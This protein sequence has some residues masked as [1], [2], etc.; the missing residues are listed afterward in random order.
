MIGSELQ[1]AI[2]A[3]LTAYPAIAGGR[4]YDQVT[5]GAAHPYVTI[6]D[7]QVLDDGNSCDDGWEV[8]SDIHIWSRPASGSKVEAKDLGAAI[9]GRILAT[10]LTV[11]GFT[12]VIDA[13]ESS[14][15]FRDPDGITEHVVLTFRHVLQPA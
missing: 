10:S 3:A 2:F 13:L 15:A 8:F 7:D 9:V 5:P 4:I 12:V 11:T 6:G 1:K 14:R